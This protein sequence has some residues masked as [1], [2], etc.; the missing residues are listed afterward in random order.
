MGA[1]RRSRQA[2]SEAIHHCFSMLLRVKLIRSV[3]SLRFHILPSSCA[4]K[5]MGAGFFVQ[6]VRKSQ[7]LTRPT[8]LN[9]RN[10]HGKLLH[11]QREQVVRRVNIYYKQ[12]LTCS[13]ISY[14]NNQS[15]GNHSIRT[16]CPLLW[17]AATQP[18]WTSGAAVVIP[19][20]YCCLHNRG[21][22]TIFTK[23]TLLDACHLL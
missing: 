12:K 4:Y 16:W 22:G 21:N 9:R 5:N 13:E 20:P 14:V 7:I 6:L 2:S 18:G 8:I 15:G 10:Y 23:H 3:R 11:G 19:C 1:G 17:I